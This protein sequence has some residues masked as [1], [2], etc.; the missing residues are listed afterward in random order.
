MRTVVG[1]II[2]LFGLVAFGVAV[3]NLPPRAGPEF[4]FGYFVPSGAIIVLGVI[5]LTWRKRTTEEKRE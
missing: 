1:A 3:A 2:L 5:I 4:I